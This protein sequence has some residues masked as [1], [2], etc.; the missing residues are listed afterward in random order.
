VISECYP[1]TTL[2]GAQ[3]FGLPDERPLYKRKP[4][5]MKAAEFRPIRAHACDGVIAR[6][7]ALDKAGPRLDIR[8]HAATRDLIETPSPENDRPYKHREDLIDA[9][10]CAWT[11]LLWQSDSERCSVLGPTLEDHP[12]P[13]GTIIG[14]ARPH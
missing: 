10:I 6:L 9:A 7:A 13:A 11:A 2:V 8:T 12:D 3:E 1:Y 4:K 14:P 5:K